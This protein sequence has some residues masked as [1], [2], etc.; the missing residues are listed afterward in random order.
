MAK[1]DDCK[2]CGVII[3]PKELEDFTVSN[4]E[5]N[6]SGICF[7]CAKKMEKRYSF[8][9]SHT[10]SHEI[11]REYYKSFYREINNG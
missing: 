9:K 4:D 10:Y 8:S 1:Y 5:F 11:Q 7:W 2:I 6:E 3:A